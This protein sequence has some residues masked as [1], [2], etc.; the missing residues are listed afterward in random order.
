M[1]L[2]AQLFRP[3]DVRRPLFSNGFWILTAILAVG[4]TP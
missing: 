3:E 1:N 4:E 2:T